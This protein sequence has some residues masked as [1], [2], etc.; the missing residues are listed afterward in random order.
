[1]GL[2]ASLPH[3]VRVYIQ[4]GGAWRGLFLLLALAALILFGMLFWLA[5][6]YPRTVFELRRNYGWIGTLGLFG[7]GLTLF[8]LSAMGFGLRNPD[9]PESLAATA[10]Q[11]GQ[12]FSLNVGASELDGSG[13]PNAPVPHSVPWHASPDAAS[14]VAAGTTMAGA[15]A[16]ER[17]TAD[18]AGDHHKPVDPDKAARQE[19]AQG[20]APYMMSLSALF[21]VC[22][23]FS[24][25][26]A[27]FRQAFVN[28]R[29]RLNSGHVVI[30]GLGR[31][32][33]EIFSDLAASDENPH[34][35]ARTADEDGNASLG[36]QAGLR[37]R[38][39][40]RIV[41]IEPDAEN[42]H[43]EWVRKQ[44]GMVVIGDATR[45]DS[46]RDA[47]IQSAEEIFLVTGSDE[48]NIEAVIETRDVLKRLGRKRRKW[49][50]PTTKLSCRIH[51]L[52][53]DLE[54][55]FTR[56]HA[57]F[58]ESECD[59]IQISVFNA[60]ERTARRLIEDIVCLKVGPEEKQRPMRPISSDEVAHFVIL[61][62]HEF[63]Q[64][65]A[66]QLA[67]LAHFENL[68]RLR[69]TIVDHDIE[70]LA[71][72]FLARYP[73][74]SAATAGFDAW[75]FDPAADAWD[76]RTLRPVASACS[77]DPKA[78]EYVANA[79]FQEM[80]SE[81]TS[82]DFIA[83]LRRAFEAP[84][85]RPA[86]LV[87]FAE[88]GKNFATAARLREKLRVEGLTDWPIFVWIPEQAELSDLL[89]KQRKSSEQAQGALIPFGECSGST[90]YEEITHS[91]SD[92]LARYIHMAWDQTFSTSPHPEWVALKDAIDRPVNARPE[93]ADDL[94]Q[95]L[96]RIADGLWD[97]Q[98]EG[99]RYSNRSAAIHT[100]VKLAM[101]KRRVIGQSEEP[102][103]TR[104]Q[105]AVD[106][107]EWGLLRQMEHNRWV[108]ERLLAGWRYDTKKNNHELR[109]PMLVPW[110]HVPAHEQKKDDTLVS[111][112]LGLCRLG[113]LM[114]RPSE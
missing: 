33:R 13:E 83:N 81:I 98:V 91:W 100:V 67:E 10:Y 24:A 71:A 73:R 18:P 78:I 112:V 50:W 41:V 12:M 4:H 40:R 95:R 27:L 92:W 32:G 1:M 45:E 25:I 89:L 51:I 58:I 114:T 101:L 61:G 52:N 64:T 77:D 48:T 59:Q 47:G 6:R 43:V 29:L 16:E 104:A 109:H 9:E 68:K 19:A 79:R 30:C 22:V 39:Q 82:D 84:G 57:K 102:S 74:F 72:P 80:Y 46:L 66:L 103:Q 97:S 86:I 34:G 106:E 105:F 111:T 11:I 36:V 31:I 2:L 65:L 7:L 42:D 94:F 21:I 44:G 37:K 38:R 62:F 14:I 90:S 8:V 85:V 76:S 26:R 53:R 23:G 99:M 93:I 54:S 5:E 70:K 35:V 96:D 107:P 87:C 3:S 69:L 49:G 15:I 113:K 20:F 17:S 110:S 88:D 28:I 56:S 75:S 63:G 108:A 60:L 55:I